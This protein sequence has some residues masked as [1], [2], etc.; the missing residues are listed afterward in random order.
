MRTETSP[1]AQAV[2]RLHATALAMGAIAFGLAV[3]AAGVDTCATAAVGTAIV[4]AWVFCTIAS[5]AR[6]CFA[7]SRRV[8]WIPYAFGSLAAVVFV[9][10][11]APELFPIA[12]AVISA[13][14]HL[15][16]SLVVTARIRR[17]PH[18]EPELRRRQLL[19]VWC[20]PFIGFLVTSAF[21]RHLDE[22]T[23]DDGFGGEPGGMHH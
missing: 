15:C 16:G 9:L 17:E 19:F 2:G 3:L 12:V 8:H 23:V 11:W 14:F 4:V 20:V 7:G 6:L 21:Y 13:L 1:L 18:L 10:A 22:P 5:V